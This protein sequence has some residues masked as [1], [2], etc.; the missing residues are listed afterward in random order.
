MVN[1]KVEFVPDQ[2][3]RIQVKCGWKLPRNFSEKEKARM[4]LHWPCGDFCRYL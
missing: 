2:P 3:E 1:V 4:D